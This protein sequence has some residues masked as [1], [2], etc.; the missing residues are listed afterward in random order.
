[1]VCGTQYF[2]KD[3][4][5]LGKGN[6]FIGSHRTCARSFSTAATGSLCSALAVA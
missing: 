4:L 3:V 1:M 5:P 2:D 6:P